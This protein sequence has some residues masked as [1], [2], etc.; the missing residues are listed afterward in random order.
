[1]IYLVFLMG[2]GQAFFVLFE[3]E[4]FAGFL[5]SIK[6][7]FVAMLG[8]FDLSLFTATRYTFISISL[9][10]IYVITIT[11]LLLNLLIAMMQDTYEKINKAAEMQWHLERARIVF[12]IE[13]EMSLDE[14]SDSR[15]K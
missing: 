14:K 9:L 11:I 4:G 10:I 3:S 6:T 12:A 7:C 2:F 13:S 5:V 15:N 8:E 1:V